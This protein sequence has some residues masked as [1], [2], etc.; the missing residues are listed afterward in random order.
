MCMELLTNTGWLPTATI[1]SVLLQV[2]MALCSQDPA[3]A[4]L[5]NGGIGDYTVGEAVQ[6]Y[7]RACQTHG[8]GVPDNLNKVSW[9]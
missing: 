5:L 6:A 3:P 9:S 8:W 2:R 1:E 7:K 4:R